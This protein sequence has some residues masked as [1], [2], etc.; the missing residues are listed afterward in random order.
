MGQEGQMLRFV[1]SLAI[2]VVLALCVGGASL[3]VAAQTTTTPTPVA[4]NVSTPF[5]G[6]GFTAGEL[7]SFWAT[8]PDGGTTPLDGTVAD[9]NGSFSIEVSFPSAGTWAVTAHGQTSGVEVI[10]T[11]AVS[12]TGAPPA[13]TTAP[14]IPGT[15][16]PA[17]GSGSLTASDGSTYPQVAVGAP[18]TFTGTGFTAGEPLAFWQTAPDSKTAAILGSQN[19]NASGGFTAGVSFTTPGFWQVTAHGINSGHEVIGRYVVGGSSA[20]VPGASVPGTATTPSTTV[21]AATVGSPVTFTATG[22]TAGE[23]VSAW[24]TAPDSTTAAL[25]QAIADSSGTVRITTT[26]AT[27]GFW[28]I[29]A[30]G[31]TSTHEMVGQYQVT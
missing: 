12:G 21:I 23:T 5:I 25:D 24:T 14:G 18:V 9:T 13:S 2:A 11:Y 19:S 26:F 28:Q 17:Q 7:I 6:T 16:L 31:V 27:P 8:T 22:F 1:R 3:T 20:S 29:T 15:T 30:H 10:S 4:V